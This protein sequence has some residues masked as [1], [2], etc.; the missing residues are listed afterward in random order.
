MTDLATLHARLVTDAAAA[1]LLD[2]A[3]RTVDSPVGPLLVAATP[4][5]VVRVAFAVE[6]HDAVLTALATAVSPRVLH[7]PGRLDDVA[8]ELDEYFA[9]RRER[10]D[11]ALDLRLAHGFRRAVV[12]RLPDIP[13]GGRASYAAVAASVGNPRAVRAVGSACAHNPVP[14]LLPCHRVVR[15][16]GAVGAYRGGPAAKALLLG[17]EAGRSRP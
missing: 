16:D 11:V 6:G 4:E 1:G 10:F 7:A 9:G 13:Y 14:L 3:Y 15:S 12:E 5:G 2:L 17:L 8:R